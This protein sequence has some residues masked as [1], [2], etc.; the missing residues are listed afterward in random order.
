MTAAESDPTV[1]PMRLRPRDRNAIVSSLRSGVVP[2][3]GFPHIQVGR[4]AEVEAVVHDLDRV[5]DGGSMVRFVV[6]DYGAG[7]TFFL[8]L[9][10]SIAAEKKLVIAR[11]DLNPGRRLQSRTG[12]ARSLYTELMRNLATR[13][14]PDGGALPAV[15]ERFVTSARTKATSADV[16]TS[17][18]I[19]QR[20]ERLSEMTNGYDFAHVINQYWRGY[21]SG[22][23]ELKEAAIRWLRGEYS[24]KSEARADLGVRTII[25]DNSFYDALKLLARFVRLSGFGGLLVCLDE[26]VNLSKLAN[27]AARNGNYEQVLRILNDCLQGYAEG[28]GVCFAGTPEFVTDPRRGLYSYDALRTRLAENAFAVNGLVDYSS[29]VLRLSNL[30]QEDMFVLLE[31]LRL[32]YASGDRN[33]FLVP[34]EALEQF[35]RHCAERVGDAYFR[36]PRTTVK[37]FLDLL[38]VLEQNKRA[39]WRQLIGQISLAPEANPDLE[40]LPPGTDDDATIPL[41]RAALDGSGADDGLATFRL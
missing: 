25:D 26:C 39:D 32:V 12:Q 4:A 41:A 28:L 16:S 9:M 33:R 8:S 1:V 37:E 27:A 30:T 35:M 22:N 23:D 24:T 6:G 18:V 29:P 20:L 7:K 36:T 3:T 21:D 10:G 13:G 31:K 14:Q 34:D 5:A 15:V 38:A 17:A 19:A 2:R 11:A 40:P